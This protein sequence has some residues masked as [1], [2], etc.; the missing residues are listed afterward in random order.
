[1]PS[2]QLKR[3]MDFRRFISRKTVCTTLTTPDATKSPSF[4]SITP[5]TSTC[6]LPFMSSL[7]SSGIC[8]A[9]KTS[10]VL[11]VDALVESLGEAALDEV[12]KHGQTRVYPFTSMQV[13]LTQTI[14]TFLGFQLINLKSCFFRPSCRCITCTA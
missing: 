10:D 1:M 13:V 14:N 4:T 3:A 5:A 6:L 12:K 2:F 7:T 8:R 9:V 11:H